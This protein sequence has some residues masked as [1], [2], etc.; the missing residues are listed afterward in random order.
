VLLV[1]ASTAGTQQSPLD[2]PSYTGENE[3]VRPAHYREWIYLSTGLGM[4]YGP[5]AQAANRPPLFDN[6]FVN[7]S[8][9][10]SF[11]E[12]GRWPDKTIFI[13]EL[14][15]ASSQG[16]INTAG[17][18]QT[19]VVAVEAAVKD[20]RFPGGWAYFDFGRGAALK[21]S[22][23][24]LPTTAPCYACHAQNTAVEQTF[25]QFYPTILEVAR[26]KGTLKPGFENAL[27]PGHR[28]P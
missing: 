19:D 10:R 17:H 25:A 15:A 11:L 26:R 18:F 4:T 9:Y 28:R 8:S 14:R 7:P 20:S 12:T 5:A 24:P 2:G 27:A 22:T 13:L 16:S 23:A 1:A 6:V 3:L 21:P